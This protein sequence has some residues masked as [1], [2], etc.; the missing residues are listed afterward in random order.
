[1]ITNNDE[2][3]SPVPAE[4]LPPPQA[5]GE[6]PRRFGPRRSRSTAQPVRP[7]AA[8]AAADHPAST[9]EP[10]QSEVSVADDAPLVETMAFADT[11][12]VAQA[13]EVSLDVPVA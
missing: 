7:S 3:P 6:R 5:G 11:A 4:S 2:V 10:E 12:D 13:L 1:M 8:V 9:P